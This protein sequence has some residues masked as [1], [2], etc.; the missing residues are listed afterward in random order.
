MKLTKKQLDL[1]KAIEK[2]WLI[3]NG[4][5]GYASSTIVGANTR[6]YHGLL[7]APLKPP[8]KRHLILS[9]LDESI[10]LENQRFDLYTNICPNY[11]SEGYKHQES[12]Q[13]E[14]YPEFIY[15]VAN[16]KITKKICMVY[17][18]NTVVIQYTIKND[19]ASEIKMTIA[20]IL[21]FRDF[22]GMTS[23]H[24]F[25]VNQHIQDKVKIEIDEHQPIFMKCEQAN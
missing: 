22:H 12:F 20:P 3:S 7:I 2:E 6:R 10:T 9:K 25:K 4:I 18:K 14:A 24:E 21:N 19:N 15:K 17:G 5:G 11:I 13:K 1:K 23:H 8:A 16:V